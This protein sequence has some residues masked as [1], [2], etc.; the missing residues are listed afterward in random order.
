MFGCGEKLGDFD[1]REPNAAPHDTKLYQGL[2]IIRP[3]KDELSAHRFT[4]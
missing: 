1:L 2:A 4:S 3:V